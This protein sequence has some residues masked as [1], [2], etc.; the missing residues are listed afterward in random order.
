MAQ[1]GNHDNSSNSVLWGVTEYHKRATAANRN[2]FFG[3]TTPDAYI[4][5]ITVGQ[6]GADATE[7]DVSNGPVNLVTITNSGSGYSTNVYAALTGGGG[8]GANV[9]AV[10]SSTGRVTS[11]TINSGGSSYE[12]NPTITIPA[13]NLI[14]WNGNTAVQ[15][16]AIDIVSANSYFAVGDVVTYA[17]NATSTPVGLVNNTQYFVILANTTVLQLSNTH[18]GP[19]LS[20]SAASGN[21][22]T[23]G[24]ATFQGQTATA[25]AVVGGGINKG[26]THSGWVIRKVGS[27]GRAGRVQYETLVAMGSITGDL[28]DNTV[29]PNSN[30]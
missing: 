5:G 3:N 1:W 29:L 17:G 30:T 11:T 21:S 6:Y 15:S 12:T 13:P 9:T 20:F 7:T 27:G 19:A 25:A 18:S 23:A 14:I 2:A 28:S 10:V 16:N 4:T 22:V 24:G 8:S 26:V